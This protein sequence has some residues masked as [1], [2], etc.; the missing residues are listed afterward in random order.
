MLAYFVKNFYVLYSAA[1]LNYLAVI[2]LS[3]Y[4]ITLDDSIGK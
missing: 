3:L 2:V 1:I 4:F